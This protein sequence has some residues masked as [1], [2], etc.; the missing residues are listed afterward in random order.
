MLPTYTVTVDNGV[1]L[2]HHDEQ[3]VLAMVQ[4][5]LHTSQV[6]CKVS[7]ELKFATPAIYVQTNQD[8]LS[9]GEIA[10]LCGMYRIPDFKRS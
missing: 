10:W 4:H 6:A 5:L 1:V 7:V 9:D 8:N 3:Q 2:F